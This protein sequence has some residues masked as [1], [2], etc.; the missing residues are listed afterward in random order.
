[1]V[2][3]ASI[4]DVV[5]GNTEMAADVRDALRAY[6]D[7]IAL[8]EP[9]QAALW[10]ATG[11]TLTQISVLRQLRHGPMAAGQLGR[12]VGL[13]PASIT[14]LLDRLEERSLVTR[15]RSTDDRRAVHVHLTEEGQRVLG[16][17]KVLLGS[18]IHRAIEAMSDEE[19][20]RMAESLNALVAHAHRLAGDVREGANS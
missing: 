16:E 19:R 14:H 13:S 8:A 20:A 18:R 10:K 4:I 6:L 2:D 7:A 1:M 3:A 5:A 12:I 11:V 15:Q 9:V 17:A